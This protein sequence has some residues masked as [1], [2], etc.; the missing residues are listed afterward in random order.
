MLLELLNKLRSGDP[1]AGAFLVSYAG[2]SLH[3]YARSIASDLSDADRER[4]CELAVERAV[5]KIDRYDPAKGSFLRWLRTFVKH[6][7]SDW[8]AGNASLVELDEGLV[9]RGPTPEP[10]QLILTASRELGLVVREL[11]ATDQAIIDLRDRQGLSYAAIAARLDVSE[12]A[13][14]QRHHRALARLK[15]HSQG[16]PAFSRFTEE[17]VRRDR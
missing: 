11:S 10:D 3:G 9:D 7:A 5:R 12:E 17:V 1:N 2:P 6:A 8:R 15:Q 14:R 13:C 4:I 16:R